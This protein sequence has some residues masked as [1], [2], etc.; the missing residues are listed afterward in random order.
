MIHFIE[1]TLVEKNPVYAV[2]EAGGIGYFLNISLNTYTKLGEEGT[3]CRLLTYMAIKNEAATP[4]GVTLYGFYTAEE[5][6]MYIN[7]ISVNG[8]GAN[9]ARLILS[10]LTT[11]EI[12]SALANGQVATFEKVKGIGTKTA[13]KIIIDLKNKYSKLAL[14]QDVVMG[15]NNTNK[16]EALSGLMI[17]GFNKNIAEKAIDKIL[18]SD[19][20]IDAVEE[21]IKQALKIL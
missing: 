9:T 10:S 13:Q 11:G 14:E 3:K 5:R 15:V 21:L 12:V 2:I 19:P 16:Q 17:L 7:L 1:G 8:V 6:D 4:V 20:S 18:R